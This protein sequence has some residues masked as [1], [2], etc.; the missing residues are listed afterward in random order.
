MLVRCINNQS[1]SIKGWENLNTIPLTEVLEI[2]RCYIVFGIMF[3]ENN[4]QFDILTKHDLYTKVYPDFLFEVIDNRL[5]RFF[6]LGNIAIGN[7]K[8]VPFI[9][10]REWVMDQRFYEKLVNGDVEARAIFDRY[11]ELMFLEYKHPDVNEL[12]IN[13]NNNWIQCSVCAEPSELDHPDFEMCKCP[14]CNT[15]LINPMR[16]EV[17]PSRTS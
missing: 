11:K 8:V 12:A 13:L 16:C 15:V 2:N 4:R 7:N 1:S 17:Q 9:S 14:K 6:T 5:S 3:T 10:F